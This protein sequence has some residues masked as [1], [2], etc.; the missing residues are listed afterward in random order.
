M[1]LMVAAEGFHA[2]TSD[3]S[4]QGS[5]CVPKE[6]MAPTG[7]AFGAALGDHR[8]PPRGEIC[9]ENCW[10]E[11]RRRQDMTGTMKVHDTPPRATPCRH[12]APPNPGCSITDLGLDQLWLSGS[13]ALPVHATLPCGRPGRQSTGRQRWNWPSPTS[14]PPPI[15]VTTPHREHARHHVVRPADPSSRRSGPL[16]RRRIPT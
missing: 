15:P 12:S 14:F 3:G 11:G 2:G 4:Q 10:Q 6:S 9:L 1:A 13:K 8:L 7:P 16:C 5:S